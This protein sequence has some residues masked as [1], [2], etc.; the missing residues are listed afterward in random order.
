MQRASNRPALTVRRGRGPM[1]RMGRAPRSLA[2]VLAGLALVAMLP[3]PCPCPEGASAPPSEHA[4]CA[5]P[6]G[7]SAS[8]HGCCDDLD[9]AEADLLTPGPVPAPAPSAVA[10]VRVEPVA[11]LAAVPGG[12]VVPSVSPPPPVLRI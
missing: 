10:E 9:H 3:V 5:P 1:E 2:A 7:V 8:D 6:L 4:C 12:S 11:R